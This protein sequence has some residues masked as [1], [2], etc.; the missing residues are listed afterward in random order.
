MHFFKLG[1]RK[2]LEMSRWSSP[3]T[4]S[5]PARRH[6]LRAG[7]PWKSVI[8][9]HQISVLKCHFGPCNSDERGRDVLRKGQQWR[10][11]PSDLPG[12]TEAVS[13]KPAS[14][15]NKNQAKMRNSGS[16]GGGGLVVGTDV[17]SGDG[18]GGDARSESRIRFGSTF[19]GAQAAFEIQHPR[20]LKTASDTLVPMG[21][22]SAA[23]SDP[24]ADRRRSLPLRS[25]TL[26][27]LGDSA[28]RIPAKERGLLGA[29]A[30]RRGVWCG[31]PTRMS[32][33]AGSAV[34]GSAHPIMGGGSSQDFLVR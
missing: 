4:L 25:P 33:P 31:S 2:H 28:A 9:V 23:P 1:L 29:A 34:V 22:L 7:V 30:A 11:Q 12:G 32:G 10:K 19:G 27:Q 17:G 16:S 8:V 26:N 3:L 20:L 24:L 15:I 13:D 21:D 14:I 18:S 5:F 6:D